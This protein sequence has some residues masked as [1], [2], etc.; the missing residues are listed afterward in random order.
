M[1]GVNLAIKINCFSHDYEVNA[2]AAMTDFLTFFQSVDNMVQ[3][4]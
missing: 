4:Q 2:A 3:T 1:N